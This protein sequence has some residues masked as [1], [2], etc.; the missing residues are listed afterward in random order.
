MLNWSAIL[1]AWKAHVPHR[2][3]R[4]SFGGDLQEGAVRTHSKIDA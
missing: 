1:Q 3:S 2:G 4:P